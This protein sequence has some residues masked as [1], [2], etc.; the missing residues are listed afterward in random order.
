M[1][2]KNNKKSSKIDQI[3][4]ERG[5]ILANLCI[6][7]KERL[8]QERIY[9][10]LC[11]K[12]KTIFSQYLKG[13]LGDVTLKEISQKLEESEINCHRSYLSLLR[14]D[15]NSHSIAVISR[16][17]DEIRDYVEFQ[18]VKKNWKK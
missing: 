16:V 12:E 13:F 5:A 8:E 15:T 4:S 3:R 17:A 11:D 9:T 6:A 18:E 2:I 1:G 7:R 10:A 14:S